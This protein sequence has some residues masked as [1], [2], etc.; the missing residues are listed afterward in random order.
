MSDL[1]ILKSLRFIAVTDRVLLLMHRII[2]YQKKD[3]PILE[4]TC[5]VIPLLEKPKLIEKTKRFSPAF[6]R[7]FCF[8]NF[9]SSKLPKLKFFIVSKII[10]LLLL[11]YQANCKKYN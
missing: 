1:S 9:A 11:S 3:H 10:L 4:K 8:L 7:D 5:F 6:R 2:Q